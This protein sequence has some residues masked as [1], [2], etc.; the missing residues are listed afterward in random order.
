M[1]TRRRLPDTRASITHRVEIRDP[2]LGSI[3]AYIIVG[4]YEDSTPGEA[5][6][7]IGKVGST[8]GGLLDTI[9][10]LLSYSFQYGIPLE[11]L[12]RKLRGLRYEPCG[13]TDNP[14]IPECSSLADYLSRWLEARF[15]SE[16]P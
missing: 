13:A 12:C 14:D 8:L 3:D 1:S 16:Q 4:L 15:L 6:I 2:A 9:G 10:I 5:F 7:K 11:D